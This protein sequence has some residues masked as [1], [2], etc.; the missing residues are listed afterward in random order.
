MVFVYLF[1]VGVMVTLSWASLILTKAVLDLLA[2]PARDVD[3]SDELE[4]RFGEDQLPKS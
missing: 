3:D 1:I 4:A 2:G